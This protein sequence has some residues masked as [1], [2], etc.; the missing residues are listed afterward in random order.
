[1]K[2]EDILKNIME[3]KNMSKAQLGRAVG[4][5][6]AE[7]AKEKPS[8]ATDVINKRMKQKNISVNVLNEML[9]AMGYTLAVVPIGTKLDEKDG[10]YEV[11]S[12]E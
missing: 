9:S 6:T 1:M 2:V 3:E 10:K 11:S 8:K 4:V 5:V 7:E 12:N